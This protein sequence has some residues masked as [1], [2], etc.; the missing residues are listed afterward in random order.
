MASVIRDFGEWSLVSQDGKKAYQNKLN[1]EICDDPPDPVLEALVAENTHKHMLQYEATSHQFAPL[2]MSAEL[3]SRLRNIIKK[4]MLL[5]SFGDSAMVLRNLLSP[6]ECESI[7]CQAEAFGLTACGYS[8][9]MRVTDR[10]AVMGEHLAVMLFDRAR[11]FLSDIEVQQTK[12]GVAPFGVPPDMQI[13]TWSPIGLNPCFRVCRYEPGGFFQPHFDGGFEYGNQ[14]RSIKTFML[15]LN[16]GFAGGPTSFYDESQPCYADPDPSKALCDFQPKLGSCVAFNHCICH[17][18]GILQ[19]GR[20]YIL[21]TEVMYQWVSKQPAETE[22][23]N[24]SEL[25]PSQ[26]DLSDSE[27]SEW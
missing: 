1:G 10:V 26:A 2:P 19:S 22:R 17:D 4:E 12:D 21:R 5:D 25:E 15:Y 23:H 16:D 18:G 14:H 7:I 11:P 9:K 24:Q 27:S 3:N 13:G 8:A 6:A 20:K